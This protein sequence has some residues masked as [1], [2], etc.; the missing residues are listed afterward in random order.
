MRLCQATP[1]GA[2]AGR[3]LFGFCCFFTRVFCQ[4]QTRLQNQSVARSLHHPSLR[5]LT[6]TMIRY[7]ELPRCPREAGCPLKRS[8]STCDH[9]MI[10]A[11]LHLS[12]RTQRVRPVLSQHPVHPYGQLARDHHLGQRAMW[13]RRQPAIIPPQLFVHRAAVCAASTKSVRI[14]VLPCLLM[15]RSR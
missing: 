14:M 1:V 2:R 4:H 10:R 13:T 6:A 15:D 11:A 9:R 8:V 7:S 12:N 3:A 5:S